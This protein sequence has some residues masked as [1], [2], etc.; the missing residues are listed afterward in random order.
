MD[1]RGTA[2]VIILDEVTS[3]IDQI[4]AKRGLKVDEMFRVKKHSIVV[5]MT[6]ML[7][8]NCKNLPIIGE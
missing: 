6:F 1:V 8:I 2:D 4:R 3:I 7:K 5:L